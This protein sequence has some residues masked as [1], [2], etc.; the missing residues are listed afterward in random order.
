MT[1]LDQYSFS[2]YAQSFEQF[3]RIL[4]EN[5]GKNTNELLS[6]I[7][8]A[9]TKTASGFNINTGEIEESQKLQV[10]DHL[11]SKSWAIRLASDAAITIL[12]VDQ[13]P[14]LIIDHCLETRRRTQA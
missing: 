10:W 3:A 11:M 1:G 2:K 7:K 4:V 9:N 6:K 8:S 14:F 13:V 12:R 5:A